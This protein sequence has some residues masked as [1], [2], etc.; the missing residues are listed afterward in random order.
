[1]DPP[2]D[3]TYYIDK[4]FRDENAISIIVNYTIYKLPEDLLDTM[5]IFKLLSDCGTK[6]MPK[7]ERSIT[8]KN[9]NNAFHIAGKN[10]SKLDSP[11][12]LSEHI[13]IIIF[14]QYLGVSDDIIRESIK[15]MV[16]GSIINYVDKCNAMPYNDTMLFIFENYPDWYLFKPAT[17]REFTLKGNF[18]TLI[19]KIMSPH[20][21]I[22]FQKKVIKKIVLANMRE[23]PIGVR[24]PDSVTHLNFG[25]VFPQN[26]DNGI[27]SHIS[28]INFDVFGRD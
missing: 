10:F 25:N 17:T 28:T 20:Y 24:I 26:I 9:A 12:E 2:L 3:Q 4:D 19:D 5:S 21:P 16:D 15:H 8:P 11:D 6:T 23:P 14:M 22:D 1:M 13:E 18:E 27:P 7:I